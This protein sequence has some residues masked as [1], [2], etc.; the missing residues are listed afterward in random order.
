MNTKPRAFT[1]TAVVTF[2]FL[3]AAGSLFPGLYGKKTTKEK[4][5]ATNPMLEIKVLENWKVWTEGTTFWIETK[6]GAP[7]RISVK[8]DETAKKASDALNKAVQR[9]EK[10]GAVKWTQSP[11]V[12]TDLVTVAGAKS[13][14]REGERTQGEEI[15]KIL[16]IVYKLDRGKMFVADGEMQE[17]GDKWQETWD[18]LDDIIRYIEPLKQDGSRYETG[19]DPGD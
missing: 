5:P 2:L 17:I 6:G 9:V 18:E 4:F 8:P 10:I 13:L 12:E 16:I 19:Q 7:A 3:A 15:Y 14:K 11:M 1:I